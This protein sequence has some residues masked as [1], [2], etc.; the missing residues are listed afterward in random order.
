MA[1]DN[2]NNNQEEDVVSQFEHNV[3]ETFERTEEFIRKNSKLI[4]IAVVA[5]ALLIGGALFYYIS[6][7][8]S[9][10]K[11]ENDELF[12]ANYAFK[13]DSFNIALNG[14]KARKIKGYLEICEELGSGKVYQIAS[15]KAGVCYMRLGQFDKAIEKLEEFNA[16]DIL[17]APTAKGLIGDCQVE[18]KKLQEAYDSYM[19]AAN[20][21]DN[22]LTTPRYLKKAG[23]V[24]E[25]LKQYDKAFECY[26][27][28]KSDY[29]TSTEGGTID[30]Y[31]ARVE[32]K[33]TK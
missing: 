12:E 24:A 3:E 10:L 25:E 14:D 6:Y 8:P 23:I 27:K 31:I 29:S 33:N 16:N 2:I 21:S 22:K 4:A 11:E 17:V 15:Y 18:L 19:E 30:A 5:A 13:M 9:K 26:S 28:I 20:M 7:A 1:Q 32:A